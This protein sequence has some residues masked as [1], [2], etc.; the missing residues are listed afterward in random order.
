[1]VT[2]CLPHIKV[3]AILRPALNHVPQVYIGSLLLV[4]ECDKL[5]EAYAWQVIDV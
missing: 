2:H 4:G 3:E 1:M 5:L